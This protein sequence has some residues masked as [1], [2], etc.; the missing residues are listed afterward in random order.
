MIIKIFEFILSIFVFVSAIFLI[1]SILTYMFFWYE[2]FNTKKVNIQNNIRKYKHWITKGII[3]NFIYLWYVTICYP[4][5]LFIPS[6]IKLN[7]NGDLTIVLVHGLFHNKTAWIYFV[8][9]L[10]RYKNIKNIYILNYNSYRSSFEDIDKLI[11]Q[12]IIEICSQNDKIILIG[13]SL[14]GLFCYSIGKDLNICNHIKAIITLGTPYSGS[15]LAAFG[16]SKLA[17]Q[18]K[19]NGRL[20]N[21]LKNNYTSIHITG[22][23]FYS[24]IDNLVLPNSSL[25]SPIKSW[26]EIITNPISHIAMLYNK[27]IID[28]II[29]ILSKV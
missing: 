6:T 28:L 7:T 22:Y 27:R 29:K 26:V 14:G 25:K 10:K 17:K 21:N 9:K 12:K 16:I 23:V 13:H 3:N 11:K 24:P 8:N 4:F 19:Y 15:K 1:F 18:L 5:N 2:L 20:I